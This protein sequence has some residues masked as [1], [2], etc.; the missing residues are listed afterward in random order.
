MDRRLA[1]DVKSS[2]VTYGHD[3]F[4]EFT[5]D[6]ITE[7]KASALSI[8]LVHFSFTTEVISFANVSNLNNKRKKFQRKK[9]VIQGFNFI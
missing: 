8:A 9:L 7:L 5:E 6:V 4:L 1:F 2:I 3:T